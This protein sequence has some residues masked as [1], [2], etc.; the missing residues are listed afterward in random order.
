MKL[1]NE[2]SIKSV[3]E[4]HI[5]KSSNS[6]YCKEYID[7]QSN[8]N[9]TVKKMYCTY[10]SIEDII[11]IYRQINPLYCVMTTDQSYYAIVNGGNDSKLKAVPIDLSYKHNIKLLSMVFHSIHMY[12]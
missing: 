5:L 4:C 6:Q 9:K 12:I 1:L 7:L 3:I 11:P 2:T 8:T 10:D